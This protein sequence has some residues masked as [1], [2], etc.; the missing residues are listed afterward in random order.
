MADIRPQMSEGELTRL[1]QAGKDP[2]PPTVALELI[3]Y[4]IG[5]KEQKRQEKGWARPE[6]AIL[7]LRVF[8]DIRAVRDELKRANHADFVPE[9]RFKEVWLIDAEY[10]FW[11]D[12]EFMG[13]AIVCIHP[14]D[15]WLTQH[16]LQLHRRVGLTN[17]DV[18]SPL[19]GPSKGG[20]LIAFTLSPPKKSD[21]GETS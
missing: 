15:K 7:L 17:K 18:Y 13:A 14:P 5:E 9:N 19:E 21:A 8:Q 16:I 12:G 6:N 11:K 10:S 3:R 1:R 2:M 20:P 4:W